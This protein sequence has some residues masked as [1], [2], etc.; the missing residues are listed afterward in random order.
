MLNEEM[1]VSGS[2]DKTINI[3]N[4]KTGEVMNTINCSMGLIS[5]AVLNTG[6]TS[7]WDLFII[8]FK[9]KAKSVFVEEF[10]INFFLMTH[11]AL[12]FCPV[13]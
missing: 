9:K 5:L 1:L 2:W 10:T 13:L 7:K 8:K 3:W 4:W 12:I 6:N 11:N